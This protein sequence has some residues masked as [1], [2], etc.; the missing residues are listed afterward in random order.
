MNG[1][2]IDNKKLLIEYDRS[3][4]AKAPTSDL[5]N[6]ISLIGKNVSKKIATGISSIK[7]RSDCQ[8][9]AIDYVCKNW[10]RYQI[11]KGNENIF[12]YYATC[13]KSLLISRWDN[14]SKRRKIASIRKNKIESIYK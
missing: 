2:Y 4:L 10:N 1:H 8:K 11:G 13:I 5:I 14:I 7:D 12:T 3:I 9:Y 6:Y